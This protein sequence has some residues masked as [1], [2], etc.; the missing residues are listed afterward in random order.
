VLFVVV[1]VDNYVI[2]RGR[3]W[4][5]G[6][7]RSRRA[8]VGTRAGVGLRWA[9]LLCFIGWSV[10]RKKGI[11]LGVGPFSWG[12]LSSCRECPRPR[13]IL[14]CIWGH[15]DAPNRV[16]SLPSSTNSPVAQLR[17]GRRCILF[18]EQPPARHP[19]S[20]KSLTLA[21]FAASRCCCALC[22]MSSAGRPS[23]QC[24]QLRPAGASL[25][26][27]PLPLLLQLSCPRTH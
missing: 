5:I 19:G 27:L 9:Y 14:P 10:L 17:F 24:V 11:G 20:S 1:V 15:F 12:F 26:L 6:D 7:V 8:A 4:R 23:S 18:A 13:Q 2:L 25:L 16:E 22:G 21:S 3:D